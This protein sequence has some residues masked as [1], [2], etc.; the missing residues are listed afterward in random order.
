MMIVV[1]NCT[2]ILGDIVAGSLEWC[3]VK[4]S[5]AFWMPSET[6]ECSWF[7]TAHPLKEISFSPSS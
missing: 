5:T 7:V 4:K 3:L 2:N 1:L 6:A